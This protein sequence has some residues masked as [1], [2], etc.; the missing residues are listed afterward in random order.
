[1][2]T[3]RSLLVD[4]TH[5]LCY[6]LVSRCV[7]GARLCGVDELSGTDFS[8]RKSWLQQR[9]AHLAKSFSVDV[10]AYA[11]MSNHFHL[12]VYFDPLAASQW[13]DDEVA[14]RW[15]NAFPSPAQR[16]ALPNAREL[17]K[18]ALLSNPLRLHRCRQSLGSLSSFMQHLKQPIAR[19]ANLEQNLC[20]HFFEQ[21]FYSGA[22]LSDRSVLAAMAYVDLNPVRAKI[23]QRLEQCLHTSIVERLNVVDNDPL[24]LERLLPPLDS[25]LRTPSDDAPSGDNDPELNNTDNLRALSALPWTLRHYIDYL[26]SLIDSE[27]TSSST[28]HLDGQQRRWLDQVASLK[29]QHR[30]YGNKQQID[31]WTEKRNMR[32]LKSP[33]P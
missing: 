26:R 11:I 6:H 18:L 3:P 8:H 32:R 1:M 13:S 33:F 22:L 7:R 21:R 2:A 30:A 9:I 10:Y 23:A 16:R 5:P 15:L 12:I 28:E 29:K 24:A 4:P 27:S 17:D 14:R 31:D 19:R 25:G 20:G